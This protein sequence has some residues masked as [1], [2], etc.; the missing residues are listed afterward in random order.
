MARNAELIRQWDILRAID[1]AHVG[2]AIPKLAAVHGVHQRTIR[3]DLEALSKAGFPLYDER[4]NGTTKWKLRAKPF[5]GLED[6]GLSVTELCALYFCRSMLQALAGPPFL[7]DLD[8]AFTK[9]EKALP[10]ASQRFLDQVPVMLGAKTSGRKKYDE[11]KTRDIISRVVGA[12]LDRR[13]VTMRYDSL[14][15]KRTKEYT[16]DPL[17]ISYAHGGIYLT[18]WVEEYQETRTFSVE[19]IRTLAVLDEQFEPRPLPVDPFAHS[20]GVYTGPP[21]RIV[22]E[23]DA[24]I[25]DFINGREWHRSQQIEIRADGSLRLQ[26]DVCNDRP[27]RAW[28]LGFGSLAHVAEPA[29]LAMEIAGELD[30]ALERYGRPRFA[31]ARMTLPSPGTLL[32]DAQPQSR[33]ARA[34]RSN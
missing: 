11:K 13:R 33:R 8:R 4:I 30:R 16:V 27:L 32:P 2:I 25:A 5:R 26:L 10:K 1:A 9:L 7:T 28:I 19:R 6:T 23:F 20:L 12:S 21:E 29:H 22:I 3:R 31:M 34:A 15:S 18:A 14:S 17:R 24:S